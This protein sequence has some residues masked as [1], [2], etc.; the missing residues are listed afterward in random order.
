MT[1]FLQRTVCVGVS[2]ALMFLA[3]VLGA[4]IFS[5]F[6]NASGQV[7]RYSLAICLVSW[8]LIMLG[9]DWLHVI[10]EPDPNTS[11][12]DRWRESVPS[13]APYIDWAEK[14]IDEL[15]TGDGEEMWGWDELLTAAEEYRVEPNQANGH[16]LDRALEEMR[17]Q[18]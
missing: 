15:E 3:A 18:T 5:A 16:R 6:T 8:F 13:A 7:V 1:V 2:V 9:R 4:A 11:V 14:T 12:H 10:R 17:S